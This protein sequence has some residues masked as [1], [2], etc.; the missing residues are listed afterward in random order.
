MAP[1]ASQEEMRT[2]AQGE[3]EGRTRGSLCRLPRP[4]H[5]A[6]E[7]GARKD[8]SQD[9]TLSTLNRGERIFLEL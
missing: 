4:C 2:K 6:G 8:V 9:W 5:R 1:T 3:A 7:E